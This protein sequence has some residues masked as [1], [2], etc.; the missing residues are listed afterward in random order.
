MFNQAELR[1]L[2]RGERVKADTIHIL[3]PDKINSM[4]TSAK[5]GITTP[6]FDSKYKLV[7]G[8]AVLGR[9]ETR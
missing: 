3:P 8:T 6:S 9:E 5:S 7:P 2:D 4:L 1:G